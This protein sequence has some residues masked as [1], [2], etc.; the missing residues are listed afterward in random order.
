MPSRSESVSFSFAPSG[1]V[2]VPDCDPRLRRGLHSFAASRLR[3]ESNAEARFLLAG[4]FA[5]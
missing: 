2:Q 4:F 1:L 3:A 5:H